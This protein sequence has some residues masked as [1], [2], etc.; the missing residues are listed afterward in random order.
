[1][2]PGTGVDGVGAADQ[3]TTV[4][5]TITA[6]VG[7]TEIS[8]TDIAFAAVAAIAGT[9]LMIDNVT[10]TSIDASPLAIPLFLL[11]TLPILWRRRA[12][13]AVLAS[14][15]VALILH[16]LLFGSLI[17]CG[18]V[19]PI[20]F[21]CAYT[22]AQREDRRGAVQGL[23]LCWLLVAV[24]VADDEVIDLVALPAFLVLTTA[25]WG[26]GRM[27]RQR[28]ALA[29]EQREQ[30][31]ELRDARD[32]RARLEVATDRARLSTELD[33]LLHRRLG[34]LAVLA[35]SDSSQDDALQRLREI[36]TQSRSTLEQMRSLVGVLRQD[37][38]PLSAQPAPTLTHLGAMLLRARGD[39]ARLRV[40]GDPRVLPAGVELS[41]YRV[42]EHLLDTVDDDENVDVD[43]CVRFTS[44]A[45]ELTVSGP[46][47]RRGTVAAAI[48]RARERVAL[49]RGRLET[50]SDA[51]RTRAVALLP[52]V[53]A[54]A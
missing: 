6:D 43:V 51:G 1:M 38:N 10:E 16:E 28:R 37:E 26:A 29:S 47:S 19:V 44:D 13:E 46:A 5:D 8:R 35:D 21:A 17:R 48:E 9:A 30:T 41:A 53:G 40:E 49:H 52:L 2:I 50:S 27:I 4:N 45:L 23:L 3:G 24:A 22:A 54:E 11:V 32:A 42:V 31:E 34:E 15:C 18:V 33:E 25:V 20:A 14:S 12:L 39:R 36:E 7:V